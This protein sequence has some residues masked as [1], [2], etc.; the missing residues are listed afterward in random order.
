LFL[1]GQH[2]PILGGQHTPIWGGH[3]NPELGGQFEQFFQ[4]QSQMPMDVLPLLMQQ[5][6]NTFRLIQLTTKV[7][8]IIQQM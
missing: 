4:L 7:V 2:T 6:K 3:F 5:L 8:T 1:G